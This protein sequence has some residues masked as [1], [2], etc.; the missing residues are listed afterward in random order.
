[1]FTQIS[2][3][4]SRSL[5]LGRFGLGS[6]IGLL[7]MLALPAPALAA[8]APRRPNIVF[9]IADDMGFADMGA[10]GSEIRTP[11]LDSLAKDGLRF[12][13]FYTHASCSPTR[14]MLLSGPSRT[15]ARLWT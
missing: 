13:N 1:M 2:A 8:D 11:N 5:G 10:F 3:W 12:T 7:L 4:R 14:S 15:T 6:L 9:I